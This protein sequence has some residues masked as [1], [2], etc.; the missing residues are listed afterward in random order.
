MIII[1]KK[2]YVHFLT[3][4]SHGYSVNYSWKRKKDLLYTVHNEIHPTLVL[5]GNSIG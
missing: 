5:R 4:L 3:Y 1:K 2:N